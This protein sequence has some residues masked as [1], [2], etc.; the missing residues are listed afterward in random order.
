MGVGVFK[1]NEKLFVSAEF[2]G[3]KAWLFW[4]VAWLVAVVVFLPMSI[5]GKNI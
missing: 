2:Q 5:S 1:G 4:F 3:F